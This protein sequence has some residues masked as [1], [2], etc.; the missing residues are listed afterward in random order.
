MTR[1]HVFQRR[2]IDPELVGAA[3]AQLEKEHRSRAWAAILGGSILCALSVLILTI[4][5]Y[6]FSGF[7]PISGTGFKGT[8]AT[9]G[10][11][12]LPLLFLL[13]AKMPGSVLEQTVP[14]S[15]LLE[16]RFLGRQLTMGLV[17]IEMANVGPRLTLWG[18]VQARARSAFGVVSRDRT[19]AALALLADA[20]TAVL[21]GPAAAPGRA[22]GGV[23]TA[24][25]RAALP[26]P[27]RPFQ[28][29]R[30]RVDHVRGQAEAR[31]ADVT[32]W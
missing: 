3:L 17:V 13:A 26:R 9:V 8:Y 24:A 12:C 6:L 2:T 30:P 18:I 23:G 32:P 7:V 22:A 1:G 28:E 25:G 16:G 14:G 31:A 15:D 11:I 5:Y 29:R 21:P 10:M 27:G 19:A 20:N 4:V